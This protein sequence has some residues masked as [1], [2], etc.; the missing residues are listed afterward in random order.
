MPPKKPSNATIMKR[1]NNMERR[2]EQMIVDDEERTQ[3]SEKL[4]AEKSKKELKNKAIESWRTYRETLSA[5][6]LE[7]LPTL[8]VFM[9]EHSKIFKEFSKKKLD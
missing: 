7:N 3:Y 1:I 6:P 2:I 9:A 4:A 5:R 8:D